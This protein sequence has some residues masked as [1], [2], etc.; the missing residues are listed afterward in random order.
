MFAMKR[1]AIKGA[2]IGEQTA[3]AMLTSHGEQQNYLRES[4]FGS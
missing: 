2:E 4:D 1:A 3:V